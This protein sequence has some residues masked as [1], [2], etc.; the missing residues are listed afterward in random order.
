MQFMGDSIPGCNKQRGNVLVIERKRD[1]IKRCCALSESVADEEL[2]L[3]SQAN[4][5]N[6]GK[7][8]EF[9]TSC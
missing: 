9:Q 4:W 6:E 8:P 3:L 2:W 5:K 7:Q 1:A